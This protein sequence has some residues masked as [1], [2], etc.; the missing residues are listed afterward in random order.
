MSW[1]TRRFIREFEDWEYRRGWTEDEL[2]AAELRK[3]F[4]RHYIV[5]FDTHLYKTMVERDWAYI[6]RREYRYDV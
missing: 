4:L 5:N 6:A 1:S 2:K 3:K